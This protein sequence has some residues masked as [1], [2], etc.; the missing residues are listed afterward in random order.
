MLN[1]VASSLPD[2]SKCFKL[3]TLACLFI[4]TQIRLPREAFSHA[5]ITE[6]F[7]RES[8]AFYHIMLTVMLFAD[9]IMK[10][11]FCTVRDHCNY[12]F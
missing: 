4:L 5:A 9:F 2:R 1:T 10:G 12:L 11:L 8:P 6:D 7:I 3:Q